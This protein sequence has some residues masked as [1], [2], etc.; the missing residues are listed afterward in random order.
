LGIVVASDPPH[1]TVTLHTPMT[2][3]VNVDAVRLGSLALD[4]HSFRETRH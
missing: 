3:L 2:S 4:P 1:R